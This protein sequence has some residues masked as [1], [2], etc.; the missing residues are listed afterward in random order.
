M[1]W[2]VFPGSYPKPVSSILLRNDTQNGVGEVYQ[3]NSIF[4]PCIAK[5]RAGYGCGVDRCGQRQLY[6]PIIAGEWMPLTVLKNE[7]GKFDKNK[8]ALSKPVGGGT[9]LP[10]P[11]SIMME[12]WIISPVIL[13]A[14]VIS[15]P[16][17][18]LL[19]YMEKILTTMAVSM[20]C[21]RISI[22]NT[23]WCSKQKI[24]CCWPGWLYQRDDSD[25]RKIS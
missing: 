24:S 2:Q 20:L 17:E 3:C 7:Q 5:H 14:M 9:V 8:T 21:S 23:R 18:F 1:G 13:A 16:S 6:R 22:R 12:T 11:I 15:N 10:L 4:C 25:E 19:K